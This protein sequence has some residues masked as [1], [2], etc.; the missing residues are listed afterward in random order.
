VRL[1]NTVPTNSSL[2]PISGHF[3]R[4]LISWHCFPAVGQV[5]GQYYL[6]IVDQQHSMFVKTTVASLALY[7]CNTIIKSTRQ[8]LSEL[9]A[10]RSA[11][12][13][14]TYLQ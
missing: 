1:D 4:M 11:D 3:D 10:Y 5:A 9:L 2:G 13:G 6:I 8:W 12:K 14:K 7:T